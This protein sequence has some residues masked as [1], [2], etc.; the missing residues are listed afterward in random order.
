MLLKV[1]NLRSFFFLDEGI[2]RAVDDISFTVEEEE[3]VALVGESGCGKTIAAL[4]LI[5]LI[6]SPGRVVNGQIIFNGRDLLKLGPE[7]MR[8][9]RG[10]EIGMVFQEP[11]VALNPVF[12]IG[13]QIVEVLRYNM[14]MTVRQAQREAVRLLGETGIQEPEKRY[15]SYPFELSGGMQQRALISLAISCQPR[16]L[17][18][19]EPTTALDV[20]VQIEII[21]LLR[22]LQKMLDMSIL[23]ITHDMG[24]VAEM[25]KR[26]M[27]MYTGKIIETAP[28]EELFEEQKHP[29]TKGLLRSI[30]E[31]GTGGK[32]PLKGIPGAVPDFLDLP[33]GCTFHPRCGYGDRDCRKKFPTLFAVDFVRS[34]ACYKHNKL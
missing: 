5:N 31:L 7:E 34:S 17:I 9:V 14:G 1:E 10:K 30:P 21:D 16:L 25:A 11:S 15:K 22:Y 33:P 29:Y 6:P 2:L 26:V 8:Q 3:T 28:T 13:H 32:K 24:V 12:T 20:T 18:A 23:L 4:S 27:V 19:D